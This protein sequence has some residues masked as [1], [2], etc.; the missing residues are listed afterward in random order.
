MDCL[1]IGPSRAPAAV[2]QR[3]CRRGGGQ[4]LGAAFARPL[5]SHWS[6]WS[7]LP[8][9]GAWLIL[10]LALGGCPPPLVREPFDPIPLGRAAGI[11]NENVAKIRGTLRAIGAVDGYVT[12]SS[13]SRRRYHVDGTLFYHA[14][15]YLRFDLKKLGDRQFLFGSND[16]WYW[17]YGK[18]DGRYFCGRHGVP[19]DL[20]PDLPVRPDQIVNALGLTPIRAE[21]QGTRGVQRVV[22]DYQQILFIIPDG[23][24]GQVIEKEYWLDRYPSRLVR[25]VVFRDRDGVVE[26]ESALDEYEPLAAGGPLLPHVMVADWPKSEAHMRFRVGKWSLVDEVVPGDIQFATPRECRL[27]EPHAPVETGGASARELQQG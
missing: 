4:V 19:A 16:R 1:R 24:G 25:R 2:S 22:E 10:V 23:R 17:V 26:M 8:V 12:T 3:R 20:P 6:S 27:E 9:K 15:I 21:E 13:G 7:D 14:P 18:A 11:V 5:R